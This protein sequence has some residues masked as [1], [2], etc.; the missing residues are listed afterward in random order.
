MLWGANAYE[1]PGKMY[2]VNSAH[3]GANCPTCHMANA[4]EDNKVGGH[5]WEPNV[6]TCNGPS[7]HGAG[8]V[9]SKPGE[10]ESPDAAQ[11]RAAFDTT[12]Y[13]GEPGGGS[14]PIAVQIQTLQNKVIALLAA[15][16]VY[17]D[18]TVYPYF[19]KD[20]NPANHADATKFT[21]WTP[22]L[23]KAAFN[24]AF[25]IK[26]LPAAGAS[27]SYV[28]N[29]GGVLVPATSQTLVPNA[30]AAVHN[31]RYALQLLLDSYEDLNGSPLPGSVRPFGTRPATM[32]GPGQ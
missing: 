26:G 10:P 23:Y 2:G 8:A 11:F 20:P 14:K 18:D 22:P 4:S 19:F 29:G 32:Y 13:T 3:Q 25:L 1:Y 28:V 30:S 24:L 5:T 31:F 7:C 9:S 17:Y 21:A 6:A 16:G 12:N 15:R 27:T